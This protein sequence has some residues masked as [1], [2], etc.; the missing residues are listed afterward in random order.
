M[1][2]RRR[3]IGAAAALGA[4]ALLARPARA[5]SRP[6]INVKK[7]GAFGTGKASDLHQIRQAI[8]LAAEHPAGATVYFPPGEYYLG[9]SDA[10]ELLSLRN[11]KNLRFAG[12]RATLSCRTISGRPEIF[13]LGGSRNIVIEGLSFRDYGSVRSKV[14]G[15]YAI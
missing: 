12:E 11:L 9:A 13:L 7:I 2:T 4:V 1:T 15:T 14:V 10:A 8:R 5:Q 6:T 3:F